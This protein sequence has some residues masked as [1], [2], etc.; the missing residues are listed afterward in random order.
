MA[1]RPELSKGPRQAQSRKGSWWTEREMDSRRLI[2]NHDTVCRG[3]VLL[4]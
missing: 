1:S 3:R 2:C 4:I